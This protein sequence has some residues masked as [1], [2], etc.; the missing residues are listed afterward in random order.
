MP[1]LDHKR[2]IGRTGLEV[3]TLGLGGGPFGNL[4][5]PVPDA[6]V[7]AVVRGAAGAGVS[8]FD[9]APFYGFGLSERR[10]GD[11]LRELPRDS[12]VLSTKVGRLLRPLRGGAAERPPSAFKSPMP[13]NIE[14]DY[15]YDAVMRSYEDSLQRLGLGRVEILLFH[16]LAGDAHKPEAYARHMKTALESGMKAAAELKANGDIKAIGFGV[17]RVE[18]CL[19]ALAGADLDVFLLAS[20]YTLLEQETVPPLFD[21]CRERGVSI[22]AGAPFNS[23]I[24][25]TGSSVATTYDHAPAQAAVI[26]RVRRIEA[27]C[28]AHNVPMPAAALQFPLLNPLVATVLPGLRSPAELDAALDWFAAPIPDGFWSDLRS[29]GLLH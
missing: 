16:D 5:A 17:N 6:D 21:K 28:A 11:G 7:A 27:V 15:G 10:M 9:T 1:R 12:F 18:A 20:R 25:V 14:F 24:L 22:I 13:F 2:T 29:A 4:F 19:D 26:E 23:G 8:L 3:S